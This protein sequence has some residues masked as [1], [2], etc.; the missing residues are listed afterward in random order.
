MI[1]VNLHDL[2]EEKPSTLR[3]LAL[4]LNSIASDMEPKSALREVIASNP[5]ASDDAPSVSSREPQSNGPADAADDSPTLDDRGMP[6]DERIH[7]S[8]KA[9]NADGTWRYKRGVDKTLIDE[10]EKELSGNAAGTATDQ[11]DTTSPTPQLSD[12]PNADDDIPPPPVEEESD[13][14]PPP[15]A[16]E[17][18][19]SGKVF[20]ALGAA[21]FTPD[22]T[23]AVL[24]MVGLEKP[25]DVMKAPAD[26]LAELYAVIQ[27]QVGQ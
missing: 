16:E 9:I 25:L 21:K 2:H 4:F 19:D 3:A 10:V 24:G 1:N 26:K 7:A 6:W 12:A 20:R 13:D 27:A 8:S 15:P 14:V 17:P 23:K 5:L 11:A 22:E 18:I